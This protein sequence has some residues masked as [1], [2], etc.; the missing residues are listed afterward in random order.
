MDVVEIRA[1]WCATWTERK[2]RVLVGCFSFELV[3]VVVKEVNC[4]VGSSL[5]LC[6][7][8]VQ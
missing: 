1:G 7:C 2:L 8:D 6:V 3:V 5:S 4:K